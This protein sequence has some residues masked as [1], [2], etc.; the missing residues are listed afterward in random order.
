M[1]E[2]I[3]SRRHRKKDAVRTKIIAAAVRLFSRDGMDLVTVDQIAK[4]ADIGKGTIYNYF[5]AKEDIVLAFMADV[6]GK[7]QKKAGRLAASDESLQSIL[8]SFI[9]LQFR[10][11]RPYYRFVRV[12]LGQMFNRTEQFLPF[13]V[14][15][16]KMIDP[17]LETLFRSLQERGMIRKDVPLAEL[18]LVFKTVHMGLSALWAI[19]GPPFRATEK[20]LQLEMKLFCEGLEARRS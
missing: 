9:S 19:E 6:E 2:V 11:K 15:M 16:Q 12:F 8:T 13:M 20:V 4:A 10:E 3:L 1:T 17:P 18:I 5:A 14:E 7:L